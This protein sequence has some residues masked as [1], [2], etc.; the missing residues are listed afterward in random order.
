MRKKTLLKEEE[1][2]YT[3]NL[4]GTSPSLFNDVH[5]VR[6]RNQNRG[7]ILANIFE[8]YT[9]KNHKGEKSLIA[10]DFPLMLREIEKYLSQIP[11]DEHED[12]KKEMVKHLEDRGYSYAKG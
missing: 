4:R 1:K 12:A 6:L 9:Y 2:T 5:D 10:K 11:N 7:A 3:H 8:R